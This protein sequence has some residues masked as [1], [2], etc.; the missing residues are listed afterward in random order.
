[1]K[2]ERWADWILPALLG[3]V[4]A[5]EFM[6][7]LRNGFTNWDDDKLIVDNPVIRSLSWEVAAGRLDQAQGPV[8]LLSYALDYRI[9]GLEPFTYHLTSLAL[10]VLA[11]TVLYFLLRRFGMSAVAAFFGALLFGLHPLRAEVVAWV[12]ARKDLLCALF[13]FSGLWFYQAYLASSSKRH[14]FGALIAYLL[15]LASKP[16]AVSFPFVLLLQDL[17]YRGRFTKSVVFEKVPFF[18]FAAVM[19][20]LTFSAQRGAMPSPETTS[21]LSNLLIGA[22]NFSFYLEKTL[23]PVGL[24][25]FYPYPES[26]RLLEPAFFISMIVV[27]TTLISA[28][29]L[30]KKAP[31]IFFGTMFFLIT[32]LPVL[33]IVPVGNAVAADR[34]A[35]I[36]S[37]GLCLIFCFLVD[38]LASRIKT[39]QGACILLL[40]LCALALP[41][42]SQTGKRC[43]VWKDS[44]TLWSDVLSRYPD[45]AMAHYN[46]GLAHRELGN[47]GAALEHYM[48][49]F[50]L[51]PGLAEA[52]NNIAFIHRRAQRY[53]EAESYCTKAI[54]ING[55]LWE[56][57]VNLA[58]ILAETDRFD[59]ALVSAER[60][61][62][63]NEA[64]PDAWYLKGYALYRQGR[65][66]EAFKCLDRAAQISD[67][68]TKTVDELR[69]RLK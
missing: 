3:L 66:E 53:G 42:R 55:D 6:P 46:L 16:V 47:M 33:K 26:I 15:A 12:S 37:L 28:L 62:A 49:A 64:S 24:S 4:L 25:S 10:H 32:L 13:F 17:V 60:A 5:L 9:G 14:Y 61:L 11:C 54:A 27:L 36:P 39:K 69:T 40:L 65:K 56:A 35:Y 31:Y 63:L 21:L 30:R 48:K 38:S 1:M 7:C 44:V 50:E 29:A 45:L 18:L 68:F 43:V 41:L 20:A 57:H 2:A 34:Y 51:D 59:E 52:A 58:Y 22:R 8:T 67:Y 19:A 23:W